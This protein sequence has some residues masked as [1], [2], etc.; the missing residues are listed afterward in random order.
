MPAK[1]NSAVFGNLGPPIHG[2]LVQLFVSDDPTLAMNM[3][4]EDLC[5]EQQDHRRIL[6]ALRQALAR[7]SR[8]NRGLGADRP[9]QSARLVLAASTLNLPSRGACQ[10][11]ATYRVK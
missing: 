7:C 4:A 8:L 1:L 2:H 10:D 5:L 11:W 9:G 3:Q 6:E